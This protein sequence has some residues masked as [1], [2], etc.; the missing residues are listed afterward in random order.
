[1]DQKT[2]IRIVKGIIESWLDNEN[3]TLLA[4]RLDTNEEI[5]LLKKDKNNPERYIGRRFTYD[6]L[7]GGKFKGD[8]GMLKRM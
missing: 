2:A 8:G 6:C 1:M 5:V 4:R 7:C 3:A